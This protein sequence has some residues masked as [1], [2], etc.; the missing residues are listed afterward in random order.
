MRD[1]QEL[2]Y[3]SNRLVEA[4][5]RLDLIEQ[6][7]ILAAI[8]A[9]RESQ[10]GLGAGYVTLHS[11]KF[12][13]LFGMEEGSTYG[14]LKESL[15]TLFQRSV[16]FRDIDPDSG[17]DR[18]TQVRWIS[19]ASYITGAGSIQLRFT[20]EMVPYITRLETE[21]TRYRLEQIGR[22]TSAHAVRLYELLLQV[23]TIGHRTLAIAELKTI[24]QLE[25]E[26]PRLFDFKRWVVDASVAQINEHT[27][28][29][30]SYTQTKT[31]RSV[32]HFEFKVRNKKTSSG[33]EPASD[34]AYRDK[35]EA[36]GQ[37]RLDDPDANEAF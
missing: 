22:M 4:S 18:I 3:K 34:Q 32:T 6:R 26:Y 13:E 11:K 7:I 10:K 9:A 25:G 24:L 30:V 8:A 29:D 36:N 19:S 14:Q 21:Y 28:L 23:V 12:S 16:T 35:L 27:D 37:Q 20:Q 17:H 5:Y 2:V 15:Q 31:G 33:A 1:K